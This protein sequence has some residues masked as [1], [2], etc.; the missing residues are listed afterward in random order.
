LVKINLSY[1]DEFINDLMTY[2]FLIK[3]NADVFE[4]NRQKATN[5]IQ[6]IKKEY[7]LE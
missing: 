6:L 3:R 5:L 1:L 4:S 7:H 2:K